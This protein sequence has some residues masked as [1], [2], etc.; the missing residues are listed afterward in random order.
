[1]YVCMHTR[2]YVDMYIH[3]FVY[4]YVYICVCVYVYVIWICMCVRVDPHSS[5]TKPVRLP[6]LLIIHVGW[7]PLVGSSKLYVSFA[8][9]RLF[10]TPLLQ[11]R[12]VFLRSLLIVATPYTYMYSY[13][14]QDVLV[15]T[16]SRL[17]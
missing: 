4:V 13:S 15:A 17:L 7:L 10:Y 3:I 6:V 9:Y 5:Q 8:E 2:Q 11:K 12:P 1:M 16:I 14:D